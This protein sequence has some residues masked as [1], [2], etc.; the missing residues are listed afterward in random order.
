MA[1]SFPTPDVSF[2]RD[3]AA[4]ACWFGGQAGRPDAAEG[5]LG[6][7]GRF[8]AADAAGARRVLALALDACR[9]AGCRRVIG[10]V[11]GSTWHRYRLVVEGDGSPPF[12]LEPS[13]P[14]VYV[15]YFRE[16]GFA[17][18]GR[19]HSSADGDL[20]HAF[21]SHA[22]LERRLAEAGI[23]FSTPSAS[24]LAGELVRIHGLSLASFA[25]NPY[26]TP[27]SLAGFQQLYQPVITHVVPELVHLADDAAGGLLGFAFALPDV[28]GD[29]GTCIL[30]TLAVAPGLRGNGLAAALV[31]RTR[32]AARRLG[33]RRLVYALMHDENPSSR[34]I[35]RWGKA[36][37]HYAVFG[38]ALP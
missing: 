28:G 32:A 2:C 20:S 27:V 31:E 29:A 36:F 21:G 19:Y 34:L 30:K 33:Y 12:F 15:D 4:V 17:P 38:R 37:R 25:G 16:A 23:A 1:A 7:L 14:A 3:G 13:N 18:V 11:D 6:M 8:A 26:Y 5:R 10:P 9:A 22:R 35:A 24:T